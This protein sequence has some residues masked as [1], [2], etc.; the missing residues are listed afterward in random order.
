MAEYQTW[1]RSGNAVALVCLRVPA[2]KLPQ[3]RKR[4]DAVSESLRIP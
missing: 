4:F 1:V 3:L 2:V